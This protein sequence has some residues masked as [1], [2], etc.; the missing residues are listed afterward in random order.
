MHRII[1][2]PD[3]MDCLVEIDFQGGCILLRK[4]NTYGYDINHIDAENDDGFTEEVNDE[5]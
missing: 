3:I 5:I 1:S 4:Q 2:R